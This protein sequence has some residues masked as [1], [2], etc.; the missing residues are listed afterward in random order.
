MAAVVE[1]WVFPRGLETDGLESLQ[2]GE[3]LKSKFK[4]LEHCVEAD[5][6][7]TE[8][9]NHCLSDLSK[10]EALPLLES[11]KI[12]ITDYLKK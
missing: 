4:L 3:E 12:A 9:R 8:I 10:I 11:V 6:S 7:S 1:V 2:V 5:T